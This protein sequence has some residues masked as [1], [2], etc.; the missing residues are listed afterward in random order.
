LPNDGGGF[1][2]VTY[3]ANINRLHTVYIAYEDTN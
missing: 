3:Q 1:S 2:M